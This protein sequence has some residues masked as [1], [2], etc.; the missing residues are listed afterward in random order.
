MDLRTWLNQT[1]A[2]ERGR[3][4]KE[5][6]TSVGYLWQLAGGH[7]KASIELAKALETA[8]GGQVTRSDLRPDIWEAGNAA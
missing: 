2:D 5:A 6:S 7:R 4:A 8:T 3:V 1:P